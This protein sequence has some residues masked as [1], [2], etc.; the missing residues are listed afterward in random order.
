MRKKVVDGRY[1]V[2]EDGRVWSLARQNWKKV[3]VGPSGY[4]RLMMYVNNKNTRVDLHRLLYRLFVGDIP[5]GLCV[6]HKDGNKLNNSL[7]NLELLTPRENTQHAWR[8]GLC[9]ARRGVKVP[10]SK[11]SESDVLCI[12]NLYESGWSQRKL[13]RRFNVT[14]PAVHKVVS[15]SSWAHV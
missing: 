3:T 5:G 2:Y 4:L 1:E 9:G 8:L 13:A 14:Q 6:N 10:W 12:R 15:G 7:E 11:L